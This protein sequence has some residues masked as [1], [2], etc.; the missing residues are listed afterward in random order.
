M[1]PKVEGAIRFLESG[2]DRV[3]IT[4]LEMAEDALAGKAGTTIVK[5]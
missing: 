2:G 1:G 3:I 4:S 5:A